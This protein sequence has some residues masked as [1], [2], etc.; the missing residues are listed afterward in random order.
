MK[1]NELR[2]CLFTCTSFLFF[3]SSSVFSKLPEPYFA[4]R[5]DLISP[6]TP[7]LSTE[8]YQRGVF[9]HHIQKSHGLSGLDDTLGSGACVFDVDSDGDMDIYFVSGSGATRYFGKQHWWSNQTEGQ[10]YRNDGEGYFELVANDT[11]LPSNIWG[12]GCHSGDLD[13]DGIEDLLIT[14]RHEN[15]ISFGRDDATFETVQLGS[16]KFWST[17]IG[18]RDINNDGYLDVYIGNYLKF[19]KNAKTLE[20]NSGFSGNKSSFQSKNFAAQANELYINLGSR[21]FTDNKALDYGVDNPDGRTLGI[22]W[23]NQDDDSWVD[24]LVINDQG[25]EPQLFLNNNGKSFSRAPFSKQID[26]LSGLRSST[27]FT[28]SSGSP[29]AMS[30]YSSRMGKPIYLLDMGGNRNLTWQLILDSDKLES[31]SNWGMASS[32]FNGD[33]LNDLYIGAG[34]LE[35]DDDAVLMSKGQPDLLLLQGHNGGLHRMLDRSGVNLSTRSVVSSDLDNDGDTDLILTHNNAPAQL[36]INN[37]NPKYW[38]GLDVR[39]KLNHKNTYMAV[40]VI[41]SQKTIWLHPFDDSFLGNQ[42]YRIRTT[43]KGNDELEAEVFWSDGSMSR[44]DNLKPGSYYQLEQSNSEEQLNHSSEFSVDPLPIDLAIWQIKSDQ[45]QWRRIINTFRDESIENRKR[46]LNEGSKY[47]KQALV[48]AFSELLLG[49]GS[50]SQDIVESLWGLELEISLPLVLK[51]VEENLDCAIAN[52]IQYWLKEEEAMILGKRTFISPLVKKLPDLNPV[53]QVCVLYALAESRQYRPVAEIENLLVKSDEINV[54][55]AAIYS[56]GRLRRSQ[57]IPLIKSFL[58]NNDLVEEAQNALANFDHHSRLSV[59]PVKVAV[60]T[61][62][63]DQSKSVFKAFSSCPRVNVEKALSLKPPEMANLFNL[64]SKISLR[65]WMVAN[66]AMLVDNINVLLTNKHLS[67]DNLALLLEVIGDL[68]VEGLELILLGVFDKAHAVSKRLVILSALLK[69]RNNEFVQNIATDVLVDSTYPRALRI[70]AGNILIDV[71][72][73]L[74]MNYSE[75]I[76][77]EK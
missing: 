24:L 7:L 21:K 30:V 39:D 49:E 20:I 58:N 18:L 66:K 3:F 15:W 35:P 32:D 48:L 42:D 43:L 63:D 44:Y 47:K 8:T 29:T 17:A 45:V 73:A 65:Y 13:N 27:L 1:K 67:S 12:M 10:L 28:T 64:C 40:K 53:V 41:Q 72:P 37:S 11:G 9:F 4:G 70:A 31:T 52:M 68:D 5:N 19:E 62:S 38:V 16:T 59:K 76:F 33:G 55:K 22:K 61:S 14:S 23:I 60:S 26:S 50:Y 6:P 54:K 56:L 51:M 46:L 74:V 25:S 57:S 71:N 77:N 36:K 75:S 2:R 69:Y 34:L